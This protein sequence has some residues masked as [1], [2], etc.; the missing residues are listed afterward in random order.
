[1]HKLS[2]GAAQYTEHTGQKNTGSDVGK[3]THVGGGNNTATASVGGKVCFKCN[4]AGHFARHC[5]TRPGERVVDGRTNQLRGPGPVQSPNRA[6]G[7]VK[8]RMCNPESV[9]TDVGPST[10]ARV[11][12]PVEIGGPSATAA[13]V[14]RCSVFNA[15]V[16]E[17]HAC[18]HDDLYTSITETDVQLDPNRGVAFTK[19]NECSAT[20]FNSNSSN[21]RSVN[22]LAP[23]TYVDVKIKGL[24]RTLDDGGTEIAVLR[25][26]ILNASE[27]EYASV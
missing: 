2:C 14:S 4:Q 15:P 26:D 1:M 6:R 17:L 27:F 11:N 18:M 23:L 19:A 3:A 12:A 5:P 16:S 25:A 13:K 24:G 21:P 7:N 8:V 10:D 22:E 20:K 9:V